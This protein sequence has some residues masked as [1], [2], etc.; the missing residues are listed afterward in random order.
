L[1]WRAQGL[2]GLDRGHLQYFRGRGKGTGQRFPDGAAE[3]FIQRKERERLGFAEDKAQ[4]L[5]DAINSVKEIAAFH[6]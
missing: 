4:L 5:L 1:Q 2:S 6:V 3:I